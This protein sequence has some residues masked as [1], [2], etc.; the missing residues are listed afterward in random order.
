[1]ARLEEL[2]QAEGSSGS[3]PCVGLVVPSVWLPAG[4]RDGE[5]PGLVVVTDHVNLT[6]RGPLT[7]RWPG[8]RPRTFPRMTGVYQP[9]VAAEAL[10]GVGSLQAPGAYTPQAGRPPASAQREPESGRTEPKPAVYSRLVVA[11]VE[12]ASRLSA[13]EREQVRV[14]GLLCASSYLVV[15][16]IIAAYYQLTVAAVCVPSTASE[17]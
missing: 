15:P 9:D 17:G 4:E 14:A 16:V 12:D 8:A 11:G 2:A 13:F 5:L 3:A 7:G 10:G 6:L 1:M